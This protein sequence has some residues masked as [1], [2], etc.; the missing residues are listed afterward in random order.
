LLSRF[1]DLGVRQRSPGP[2]TRGGRQHWLF[3]FFFYSF[4]FV[5]LLNH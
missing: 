1:D 5:F 3:L 2:R 4:S